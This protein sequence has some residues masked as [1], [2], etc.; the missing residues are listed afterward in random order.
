MDRVILDWVNEVRDESSAIQ[1]LYYLYF[2]DFD[3]LLFYSNISE[4][5]R[6]IIVYIRSASCLGKGQ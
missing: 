4:A 1:H 5:F 6:T 2:D 3:Q